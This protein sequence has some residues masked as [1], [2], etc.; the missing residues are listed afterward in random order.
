[1]STQQ[2]NPI[3]NPNPASASASAATSA[4]AKNTLI[5][6]Y[7][8]AVT[9]H[10]PYKSRAEVSRELESLITD[11]L[12][13][14]CGLITPTEKDIHVVLLELGS[15]EEVA[16]QYSGEKDSALLS[17]VYY[18]MYKRILKIVIPI[19]AIVLPVALVISFFTEGAFPTNP[20]L[21]FG[22]LFGQVI[23][24]TFSGL[25]QAFA[26]ITI[27]FI[28]LQQQK[29]KFDTDDGTREFESLEWFQNLPTVPN[30]TEAISIW[31]PVISIILNVLFVTAFLAI[32]QIIGIWFESS[33]WT[34]LFNADVIKSLWIPIL[35]WAILGILKDVLRLIE[36]RYTIRLASVTTLLNLFMFIC[37]A[38]LLLNSSVINPVFVNNL[39]SLLANEGVDLFSM[40]QIANGFFYFNLFFVAIIAFALLID[41]VTAWMKAWK[42]ALNR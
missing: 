37:A 25:L 21:F 29:V 26:L 1:M 33:G 34:P 22:E 27:V 30:K 40:R 41:T 3:P 32:P 16:M 2:T 36:G 19:I 18:L 6:R 24:T 12:E 31:E 38:A 7:L 28:I 9:R 42:Y 4:A 15:P 39:S 10:L 8:Y 11:M 14:R 5:E 20:Y 35:F 23:G 17:G 13:D